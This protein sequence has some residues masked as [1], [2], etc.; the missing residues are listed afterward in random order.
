MKAIET[1]EAADLK[2]LPQL[3]PGD[4]VRVHVKVKETSVKE[5]KGKSKET[6]RERVQVFEGTVIGL[7]GSGARS[8]MT[9]RK[10]SFGTGVE[11][12]FPCMRGPSSASRWSSTRTCAAPSSTSSASARARRAA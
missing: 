1:V 4:T 3:T 6:E 12:I 10:V 9:V 5:E 8:T 7:R 11:R 2:K